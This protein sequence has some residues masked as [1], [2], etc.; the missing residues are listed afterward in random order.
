MAPKRQAPGLRPIRSVRATA[1][2][3]VS[4][5]SPN[6]SKS[7]VKSLHNGNKK[8]SSSEGSHLPDSSQSDS[9]QTI[10]PMPSVTITVA[11][12]EGSAL[13]ETLAQGNLAPEFSLGMGSGSEE[14]VSISQNENASG[15]P[16]NENVLEVKPKKKTKKVLKVVKK[17]VKKRV[18]KS[19]LKSLAACSNAELA[20]EEI[21]DDGGEK[22]SSTENISLSIQEAGIVNLTE[23]SED[24]GLEKQAEVM[25]HHLS[26]CMPEQEVGKVASSIY[27]PF[28]VEKCE[29]VNMLVEETDSSV[30]HVGVGV[31]VEVENMYITSN[32][33]EAS[34]KESPVEGEK[35]EASGSQN[36]VD[37]EK[38]EASASEIPVEGEK[39]EASAI[40]NPVD[41][42]KEEASASEI[43]VEG[44]K[45]EASASEILV[46]G[47]KEEASAS[48]ILV[49]GEKE[50]ASASEIP[51][52]GEKGE[53]SASEIPV[54]GEKEEASAIETPMDAGKTDCIAEKSDS[55]AEIPM[56][57]VNV[58]A[59]SVGD[60]AQVVGES[61]G[62]K[63]RKDDNETSNGQ[64]ILS[65]ELEALER[66]RRR[67]TE[68]FI[69][70]LNTDAKE[71]DVRKVFEAVGDIVEMRLVINTKTGKN[72]GYAFVRYASAMDAKKALEKYS[73]VEVCGKQCC[74]APVDGNDTIF[75]GNIDRNWKNEDVIRLLQEIGIEKIDTVTVMANPTNVE[76]NRG[77]AFLELETYKDAQIAFKK[78]QK[79]DLGQ[80]KNIKV[81]WAEP[82]IEPDEEEL[83]KVKSIYAEYLPPSWNEEKIRSHF[84]KFGEIENVVLSRNLHSSRR[85]DF[86]FINF[87]TREAALA[88]IES[89]KHETLYDEGA[90]VNV[91]V[92]LA[93]P[94]PKGKPQKKVSKST[95]KEISRQRQPS[96]YHV[97]PV[98]ARNKETP[99][100]HVVNQ[101]K[102]DARPSGTSE[103]EQL[104]AERALRKQM[105]ARMANG[106]YTRMM[107][108]EDYTRSLPG[109]KRSFSALGDDPNFS[110]PRGYTRARVENS[111]PVGRV[112][113]GEVPS[114]FGMTSYYQQP[115]A[116]YNLGH[117]YSDYPN[118][119]QREE[120]PY[121]GLG[122][123]YR[124]Y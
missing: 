78:L 57:L 54:D 44:E 69:G 66:R 29:G 71:E 119:F 30:K 1:K 72:K 95:S 9:T 79:K 121:R 76:R 115:R 64:I 25:D 34:V 73:N 47:E 18:P 103:L 22:I 31:A 36:P 105:Q 7:A 100:I 14:K 84:V 33:K 109:H 52:D 24:K 32:D 106:A 21:L 37:G 49:D 91:K 50:E 6:S 110:D 120:D 97:K 89:F 15:D 19:S 62:Y 23:S 90:Q 20:S 80:L 81:A 77:F 41:G 113:H 2:L 65:G 60:R 85:T 40:Q 70:G 3:A 96:K 28:D 35:E 75:L 12:A 10:P 56:E 58:N 68:I 38:E 39:E 45:E 42:E 61:S 116:D 112:S 118:N 88:C 107:A 16:M 87:T 122:G 13:N 104:L 48:E 83:L 102:D 4:N 59:D 74:T 98:D 111:F 26:G 63:G 114:G 27:A 123:D 55:S 43:P 82:L 94:L 108:N 51:L 86:A 46:D 17:V 117:R 99:V 5:P 11:N 8:P 92:S 67:R 124:R 101:R 93:K 53:A